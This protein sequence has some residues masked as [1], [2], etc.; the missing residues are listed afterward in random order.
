MKLIQAA[1]IAAT[2]SLGLATG[3]VQAQTVDLEFLNGLG[4]PQIPPYDAAVKDF[5]AANPDI[6]VTMTNSPWTE[7]WQQLQV[8][9]ASGTMPDI[10]RFVP[11]FGAQWFYTGQL[12]DLTPYIEKD[13]EANLADA[14]QTMLKYMTLD[15]KIYG[16]GY[17]INGWAIF[18]NPALFDEAGVP[19]PADGWTMDDLAA[20]AKT[21][22]EKLSKDGR[23]VWG[24]SGLNPDWQMEAWYRAYGT[25]MIGEDGKYAANNDKGVA[26]LKYFADLIKDG[27]M[28][29]PDQKDAGAQSNS[30][31]ISGNL[32]MTLGVGHAVTIF[33]DAGLDFKIA[34]L[35]VGPGGQAGVGLGG[36][37]VIDAKTKHP[38]EAYRFLRYITSGPIMAKVT[39]TGLPARNSAMTN[40]SAQWLDFADKIKGAAAF[41]AAKGSFQVMDIQK[42]VFANVWNGSVEP[43]VAMADAAAQADAALA[44]AAAN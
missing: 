23:K 37:Y 21:I 26:A 16:I 5:N 7:F 42:Q 29:I 12:L 11:G 19:Y 44:A 14:N 20:T 33:G 39:T 31:F 40:L 35:P 18:Y 41:N 36:S 30:L 34:R 22:S 8:R 9:T 24:F 1:A 13:P 10:W 25:T 2:L 15:G 28:P 17:D 32:A 43:A 3:A 38:D 6:K 27:A 4:L